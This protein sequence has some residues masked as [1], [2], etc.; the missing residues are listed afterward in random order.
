MQRTA[1][2]IGAGGGF[3]LS[4]A[5]E[6]K[7]RGWRLRAL[8]RSG[9]KVDASVYDESVEA[10]ACDAGAVTRAAAGCALVVHAANPPY[11]AW[12]TD[13]M[14][15]AEAAIAAARAAGA[16]LLF[17]GNIYNFG[18]DAGTL[19]T[20]NSPQ[21][22]QT[23]KGALRVAVEARMAEAASAGLSVVILR[24]GDFF[25][26]GSGSNWFELVILGGKPGAPKL[27]TEPATP[28]INH[29]WTYLPDA[30]RAAATLVEEPRP[31]FNVFHFRG[32][33]LAPGT[34]VKAVA[35]ALGKPA[36]AIKPVS[37]LMFR[38]IALFSPMMREVLEMRYL[39]QVP[40]EMDDARL[41]AAIGPLVET[42]LADAV[43]ATLA[44]RPAR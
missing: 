20:E 30:A 28:G 14:P 38:V 1:L 8:M 24:C 2:I 31:G 19:L 34:M 32:H 23:R 44:A 6:L 41:R 3:G 27:L 33:V 9:R 10:D 29:S 13:G 22:P 4:V 40:H 43:A 5:R 42:P 21:N 17:P 26:P 37:W 18:P 39:W 36:M 35:T 16:T 11:T 25:G 12:H 15:M 7:Q